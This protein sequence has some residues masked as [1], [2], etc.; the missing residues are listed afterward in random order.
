MAHLHSIWKAQN[1]P[2]GTILLSATT[3]KFRSRLLLRFRLSANLLKALAQVDTARN[4]GN[5]HAGPAKIGYLLTIGGNKPTGRPIHS[6]RTSLT[7]WP[8]CKDQS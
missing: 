5:S 1:V 4:H 8:V 2:R 3:L 6:C 7:L